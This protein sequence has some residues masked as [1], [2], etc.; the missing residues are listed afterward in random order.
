M[1]NKREEG[2]INTNI[3]IYMI[4]NCNVCVHIVQ[5]WSVIKNKNKHKKPTKKHNNNGKKKKPP[6]KR[7]K[8]KKIA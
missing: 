1:T 2:E 6:R 8:K 3:Y 7:K 4:D 5:F